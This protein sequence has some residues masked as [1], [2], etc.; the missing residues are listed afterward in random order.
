MKRGQVALYLLMALVGIFLIALLNVDAFDFVRGKNRAQNAGDA[1][2][3]AAARKQGRLLNE[4]GKLNV[5]HIVAALDNDIGEC[6]RIVM[7]QR[8]LALLGPV[9]ALRLANRAAKKNK[10][11]V[12]DEFADILR[13]HV[14]SIRLVY[15]GGTNEDGEPYP[16][17]Y[18]GA[19]GEYAAAI[20]DVIGEGLAC[21][22]DNVEFYGAQG[23]HYLLM[24]DFYHAIAGEN[25]CWFHWNAEHLLESYN[26][27]HDWSPLPSRSENSM[28]NC[29]IFNLHVRAWQGA[30]TDLMTTNEIAHMCRLY[31]GGEIPFEK[32]EQ[33]YLIRDGEQVWFLFDGANRG[34]GAGH[35]GTWFDGL[36]LAGDEDGYDFPIVGEIKPEYNVRGCAAICRCIQDVE[37]VA[38]ES[39]SS[40][41]WSAAAKPFGSVENFDGEVDVATA[42]KSFVIPCFSHIRLVPLDSVG[43][44]DLSTAD[45]GWV[46]HI[47]D[48]L[49]PY[50]ENGPGNA[51]GCFYCLQ[52][53]V[54]ERM[55]FREKG[56]RWIKLYADTC[57]RGTGGSGS[58]GGTSHGH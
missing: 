56:R 10:M 58:R 14:K 22:P 50:L 39:H 45:Y 30:L 34:Y 23:G 16:E 28:E 20:E 2:A 9:E 37:A 36:R 47:R 38:I 12:R 18:P 3:L 57:I 5:A 41:T 8:R 48:H 40:V 6:E 17:S 29:E 19:W 11:A 49:S 31:G 42:L 24:K 21:G 13:E 43:G 1:A 27:Y 33:S 25:W 44:E 52:L 32:F 51:Q 26:S 15:M 4:I 7:D 55:A 54:W 53:Q 35:W 46:T